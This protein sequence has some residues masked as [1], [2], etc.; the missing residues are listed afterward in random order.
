M[1]L[2]YLQKKL[3][4]WDNKQ[5]N[6]SFR[7]ETSTLITVTILSKDFI[8]KIFYFKFKHLNK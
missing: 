6:T 5:I 1:G 2:I 7:N 4:S 3:V 8:T